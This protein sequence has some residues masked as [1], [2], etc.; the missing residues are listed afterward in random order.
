[1]GM[2]IIFISFFDLIIFFI[3]D[4][5]QE[6]DLQEFDLQELIIIFT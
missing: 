2:V 1:M 6:F 3:S 4:D 5:L